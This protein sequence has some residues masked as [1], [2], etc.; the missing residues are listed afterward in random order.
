MSTKLAEYKIPGYNKNAKV[1]IYEEI[2][3]WLEANSVEYEEEISEIIDIARGDLYYIVTSIRLASDDLVM[4]KLACG[5][6][7]K[8]FSR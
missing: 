2:K 5:H 6:L 8:K 3:Q 7:E 1:I 4:L